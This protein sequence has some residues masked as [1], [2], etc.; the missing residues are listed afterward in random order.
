MKGDGVP[1]IPIFVRGL[2]DGREV[3]RARLAQG[4]APRRQVRDAGVQTG[5]PTHGDTR[6]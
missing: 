3:L 4:I 2:E 6:A 5:R 1:D